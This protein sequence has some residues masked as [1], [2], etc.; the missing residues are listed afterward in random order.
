MFPP[1]T[2][3][4]VLSHLKIHRFFYR[5]E[6]GKGQQKDLLSF[7][8]SQRLKKKVLQSL[9]K[10]TAYLISLKGPERWQ[11]QCYLNS[12]KY[13]GK[14]AWTWAKNWTSEEQRWNSLTPKATYHVQKDS[15]SS[16]QKKS[17][18]FT[19]KWNNNWKRKLNASFHI[20]SLITK[21]RWEFMPVG[22]LIWENFCHPHQLTL[23]IINWYC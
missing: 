4:V 15:K 11:L 19:R 12:V 13:Q 5:T 20:K 16:S 18:H 2:V 7:H 10:R 1:G 21:G 9:E 6:N 17:N 8:C 23:L 3:E 14:G 22:F